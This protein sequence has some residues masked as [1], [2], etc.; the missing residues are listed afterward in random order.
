MLDQNMATNDK[1]IPS[2][3]LN[4]I[5]IRITERPTTGNKQ[6]PKMLATLV[7][8]NNLSCDDIKVSRPYIIKHD[9]TDNP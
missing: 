7:M 8:L 5:N 9:I 1:I 3:Q 2:G 4:E 6:Y